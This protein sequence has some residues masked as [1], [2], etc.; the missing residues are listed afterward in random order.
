MCAS[1][2]AVLE[3]VI[4]VS[5]G[6]RPDVLEE[7]AAAGGDAV[8]D[9]H[10]DADHNRSVLTLAGP[11]VFTAAQAVAEATVAA[12]D[13]GS[14]VGAH[15]RTGV[16]DVVPF[17]PLRG[18]TMDDAVAA[19]DAFAAWMPDALGVP[20]RVYGPD[21]PS[22]PDVRRSLRGVAGHPT[23]GV[24]CVGARTVLVAY[25]LWLQPGV[26]VEVARS[27]AEELRSPAVRAL[28][29]DLGGLAQV[30]LNL[31]EPASV[32]PDAAFDAVARRAAVA[33]AELVGLV[34]ASVLAAI[35]P[36]RWTELDL[37]PSR[38]IEAR[39]GEAGLDRGSFG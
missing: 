9:L 13:I 23:A 16:V 10:A 34:P 25:N 37:A 21:G 24:C 8:L 26:A 29:L 15:P 5:E 7:I 4:N 3:C 14:H 31:V 20:S 12:I 2:G 1:V 38:T 18:S 35:P 11:D 17:V 27:I 6:R 39:L 30:S 33:R 19:R 28:G 22:L 32:G 36:D